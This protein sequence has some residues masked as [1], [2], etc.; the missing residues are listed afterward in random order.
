MILIN[1]S[2]YQLSINLCKFVSASKYQSTKHWEQIS[3]TSKKGDT[4]CNNILK[5]QIDFIAK[6]IVNH[7]SIC[8]ELYQV[9]NYKQCKIST[10]KHLPI[11]KLHSVKQPFI[12]LHYYSDLWIF[13]VI[14]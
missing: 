8:A 7:P 11:K 9:I 3:S 14:S 10:N 6:I 2:G 12:N 13:T 1:T 5:I 4:N